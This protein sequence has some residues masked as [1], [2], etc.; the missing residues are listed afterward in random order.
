MKITTAKRRSRARGMLP[1]LWLLGQ[2]FLA[3]QA[4]PGPVTVSHARPLYDEA[5]RLQLLFGKVVTYEDPVWRWTGDS[6][7][8]G[9]GF[10]LKYRSY[11]RPADAG[12]DPGTILA[13]TLDAYHQQTDGPRFRVIASRWGLHIVPSA[14]R[15]ESGWLVDAVNPLDAEITVPMEERTAR[16][17]F[18]TIM[19]QVASATGIG[20][21]FVPTTASGIPGIDDFFEW[22]FA[23]DP[24]RFKWGT[25]RTVAREAIVDLLDRSATTY[26]W[27]LGCEPRQATCAFNI[28]E[29][30]ALVAGP[31]GS[32]TNKL[33]QF[34]RCGACAYVKSRP[35]PVQPQRVFA[36]FPAN[37]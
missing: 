11:Q 13:S 20:M 10:Q 15:D 3:A 1:C 24:S 12:S 28:G 30:H 9:R 26:S 33:V 17:H 16:E 4:I 31:N 2:A 5:A 27:H 23:A 35:L 14:L 21:K 6:E 37:H 29:L 36:P 34:D 18:V 19:G 32:L 8:L 7:P 22:D 25:S